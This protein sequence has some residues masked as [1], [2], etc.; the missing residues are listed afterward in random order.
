MIVV[1]IPEFILHVMD[2]KKELFDMSVVWTGG[3]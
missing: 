2:G 3:S 1:N